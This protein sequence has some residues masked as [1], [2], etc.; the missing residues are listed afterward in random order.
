MSHFDS[1]WPKIHLV[2]IGL[3]YSF[4]TLFWG[5]ESYVKTLCATCFEYNMVHDIAFK[6][7][8]IDL[9]TNRKT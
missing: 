3:K 7:R 5:A 2:G 4:N 6:F 1:E 8:S 9:R